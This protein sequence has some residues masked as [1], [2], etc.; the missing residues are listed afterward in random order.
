MTSLTKDDQDLIADEVSRYQKTHTRLVVAVRKKLA[1]FKDNQTQARALTS[2]IVAT[3]L[4]EEK[5]ALQS[6]ENVAH[7]LAKLRLAQAGDLGI[8]LEQPYFARVRYVEGGREVEFKLGLA[9]C[10]EERIVDWRASPISKLYYDY[11]EGDA[12]DDDIAGRERQ[13]KITL[14]RAYRGRG[15]DLTAIELKEESFVLSRG[16]WQKLKKI[17]AEPFSLKDKEKIK[18]LLKSASPLDVHTLEGTSGYL[19]NVLSLLTPEQFALV[20]S[21]LAAPIVI[22]GAAGTGKT[23]IA[24]HRLAWLLYAAAM[25]DVE[26][27]T[28]VMVF[29]QSLA[30]YIKHLLPELGIFGVKIAT[31][32]DWAQ[33]ILNVT[34][35][36]HVFFAKNNIPR[37]IARFKAQ[38]KTL[39]N[40]LNYLGTINKTGTGTI[41]GAPPAGAHVGARFIEPTKTDPLTALKQFYTSS[42]LKEFL[43]TLPGGQQIESYLQEQCRQNRFD[44]YDLALLLHVLF[45]RDGFYRAEKFPTRLAYLVVDEAQDFTVAELKATL[46]A[47]EDKSHLVLAGDLGQRVLE[48]RDFGSW[49]VLLEE[50]SLKKTGVLTLN[51]AY[52]STYQIYELAEFI[53]NPHLKD[54]SLKFTPKFGPEPTLTLCHTFVDA[55][56]EAAGWLNECLRVSRHTTGAIICKSPQLAR[57]VYDSLLKVGARGI[58]LGDAGHFEFSPGITVSDVRQIKGLEFPHVL[59]FNPSATDYAAGNEH[60]RNLLYV[61]VTRAAYKLDIICYEPASSLIPD[62]ITVKDLTAPVT[63]DDRP[64]FSGIDQEGGLC[65]ND[66]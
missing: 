48:N 5:Q 63:A 27:N 60:D 26:K 65:E 34:L 13:G 44:V 31:F 17:L 15:N 11:E 42:P 9:S 55:I 14:K 6:D 45:Y 57:H 39:Q 40:L 64:L 62:F 37:R 3:R 59:L 50:L 16:S 8:L 52:R 4:D 18:A 38:N 43:R 35:K 56:R 41:N 25:P 58:R 29:N 33:A 46:N 51:V 66:E 20:S 47:L 21:E 2:E 12:Y 10:P 19:R 23:T 28:L 1:A 24:L 36:R 7:G 54:E 22:Q 32:F 61:A 30:S 53:R 49:E